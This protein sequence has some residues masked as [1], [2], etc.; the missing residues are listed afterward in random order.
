MEFGRVSE[1]HTKIAEL[2]RRIGE[3]LVERGDYE[4]AMH[5]FQLGL[6]Y[7]EGLEHKEVVRIY[8]EIGRVYW[9]QGRL[10][11]AQEWTEKAFDLAE[12]LLDPDE[13]ARLLYHAGIR[14]H[15][16]GANKLAEEH[17]LRSL[18]I[19]EETGDLVMQARLYQNLGWQSETTGNYALALERLE[20]GR[21]LAE[22]CR[23]ISSLSVIYETLGETHFVLG[24]WG[25]AIE[26][27]QQSLNLAEQAGLRKATSRVFSVLGDI[28]R[29][30]GR[31]T[32]A[33]EC[34]QRALSAITATGTPQSLFVVNLSLGVINMERKRYAKAR[35]F[36]NKCWA[37]TS[38]GV[39]F[40]SRMAAI[41]AHMGE[42]AVRTGELDEADV[43]AA[44]AIRL[45]TEANVRQE[46]AHA[47]MVQGMTA[48]G[49]DNWERASEQYSRSLEVLTELGDRYNL[50][51]VHAA[52]GEM[53][54]RRNADRQDRQKA[55]D[56]IHQARSIFA[57]LGAKNDLGKLPDIQ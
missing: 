12:R 43:H 56:H 29:I 32:E 22:Q 20:K 34:Y 4:Q 31:W 8:N 36:F 57:E 54:L 25:K 55:K 48:T 24:N 9:N 45:A 30:Q 49:R 27:F 17:W 16:Q 39:G 3:I 51:R 14:Y 35:E 15:H 42:L 19:S 23:D 2:S 6:T 44:E 21:N 38:H 10:K 33:D 52:F 18:E 7:L 5:Q 40:T 28:Y 26:C 41:K 53:Y 47:I 1:E 13:L 11:E 46:L 37:I 50:G